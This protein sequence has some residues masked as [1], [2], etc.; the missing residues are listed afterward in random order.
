MIIAEPPMSDLNNNIGT[1]VLKLL[2]FM[3]VIW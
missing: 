1:F 2:Y 3:R